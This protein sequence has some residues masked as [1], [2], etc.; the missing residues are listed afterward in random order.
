MPEE[1]KKPEEVKV[2]EVAKEAVKEVAKEVAIP[3]VVPAAVVEPVVVEA[4]PIVED[5]TVEAAAL[6]AAAKSTADEIKN[7]FLDQENVA[8]AEMAV[9]NN[10][11]EFEHK[12]QMYRVRK[13][14]FN[15]KQIANAY[16][17]KKYIELLR[18]KDVLLERDLI[19]LYKERGIDVNLLDKEVLEL[20]TQQRQ[21]MMTL[22]KAI[23]ENQSKVELDKYKE[24]IIHI[25]STMQGLNQEK[26]GLLEYSL[27]NR[28]LMELYSYMIWMIAEKK[29]G[30][31]WKQIWPTYLEFMSTTETSLLEIITKNG[32]VII[33][34]EL[35][36][37][38][39][40]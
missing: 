30:D 38:L 14:N 4:V 10:E 3:V 25:T 16:R 40:V 20:E 32:A 24:E 27:E 37:N 26:Q 36:K 8:L 29:E 11:I 2:V 17:M 19:K 33:T 12:G 9:K 5:K 28:M 31:I 1:T 6:N 21:L 18:D 15:E 7:M 22:G 23:K 13:T 35:S 34:E 39:I